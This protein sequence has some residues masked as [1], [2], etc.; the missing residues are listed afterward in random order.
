M[1]NKSVEIRTEDNMLIQ[2]L[3]LPKPRYA[4]VGGQGQV[5]IASNNLVWSL[6]MV[7]VSEQVPQLLKDKLYDLAVTL[8]K[9]II[10]LECCHSLAFQVTTVLFHLLRMTLTY[11]GRTQCSVGKNL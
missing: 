5:Y 4:S 2:T 8:G 11:D 10:Q 9:L 6:S 1:I 7:P 3:E